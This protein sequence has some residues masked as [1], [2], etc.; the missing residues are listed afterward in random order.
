MKKQHYPFTLYTHQDSANGRKVLAAAYHLDLE[1]NIIL[2]NVYQGEGQ[3][4]EYLKINPFGKIPTLVDGDFILW[5][6][7]AILQYVA[8][9][10]GNNLTAANDLKMKADIMQWLFWE[11]S[12]WQPAISTVLAAAVGHCLLPNL[13]AA[14][15][16]NPN[17]K[18]PDLYRCLKYLNSHLSHHSFL[19]GDELSIADLSVAGMMTYFRFV[20]FPFNDFPPLNEWYKR[21]E[22]LDAWKKSESKLWK[23]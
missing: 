17:W 10:Y 6:S 16:G 8:E 13:V 14:P 5:E 11:S 9:K 15:I 12:H 7:N 23:I 1:P 21:I 2:V 3:K 20:E 4:V 19:V 18:Y 22:S